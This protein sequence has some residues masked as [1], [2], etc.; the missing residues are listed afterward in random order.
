MFTINSVSSSAAASTSKTSSSSSS[1]SSSFSSKR[2]RLFSN[3]ERRRGEGFKVR[4]EPAKPKL[5]K[6]EE[7]TAGGGGARG[8]CDVEEI[9]NAIKECEGLEGKKLEACYAQYGCDINIVTDHYAIV[10]G[11]E[12]K[13]QD[14][15]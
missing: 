15:K 3:F 7:F 5:K 12:K 8:Y 11:V 2:V 6:A 13:S 14:E 10:A 1:S 9:K 4:A